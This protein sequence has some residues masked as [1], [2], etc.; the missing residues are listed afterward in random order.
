[1]L[2]ADGK[3]YIGVMPRQFRA[4]AMV[5]LAMMGSSAW[6]LA[7]PDSGT[8]LEFSTYFGGTGAETVTAVR[9][10][11]KGNIYVA[12]STRSPDLL[13]VGSLFAGPRDGLTVGFLTKL[14]SDGFIVYSTF[15]ERPV[16]A[17]AVDAEGNAIV[18]DHLYAGNKFS[19]PTGDV[20]VTKI[21]AAA[22]TAV[23][24][25]RLGGS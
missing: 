5:V 4:F 8:Q 23:Y 6:P 2:R 3:R 21:D 16:V 15:L 11:A 12:G 10:D 25:V 1:M 13:T 14:R 17:L 7:Q 24:S 20:V 9:V 19:G 22:A 18:A